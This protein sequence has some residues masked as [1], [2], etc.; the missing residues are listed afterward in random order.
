MI[1]NGASTKR[2]LSDLR[3]DCRG[4]V[5]GHRAT[6]V[7]QRMDQQLARTLDAQYAGCAGEMSAAEFQ[8]GVLAARA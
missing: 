7:S 1:K 8:I 6:R 3:D 5:R 4:K 2:P